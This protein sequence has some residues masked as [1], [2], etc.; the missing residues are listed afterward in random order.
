M[1]CATPRKAKGTAGWLG[2]GRAGLASGRPL[3]HRD[4]GPDGPDGPEGVED[5]SLR[6]HAPSRASEG[7]SSLFATGRRLC[8]SG[9]PPSMVPTRR[10][11]PRTLRRTPSTGG[12]PRG[13]PRLDQLWFV[14]AASSTGCGL[15]ASTSR[16]VVRR[17]SPG[18]SPCAGYR[19]GST[20]APEPPFRAAPRPRAERSGA[21]DSGNNCWRCLPVFFVSFAFDQQAPP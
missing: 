13:D 5:L 17:A 7:G 20:R 16:P 8:G 9:P 15:A 21:C 4:H 11:K 12:V 2:R 14:R 6:V 19:R 18:R 3:A 10:K 1:S